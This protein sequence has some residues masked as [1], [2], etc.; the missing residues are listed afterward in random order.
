M[1]SHLKL[2]WNYFFGAQVWICFWFSLTPQKSLSNPHKVLTREWLVA[3]MCKT[4]NYEEVFKRVSA[5]HT[6]I[7]KILASPLGQVINRPGDGFPDS[8]IT[9]ECLKQ[10]ENAGTLNWT[11]VRFDLFFCFIPDQCSAIC[12]TL[13]SREDF[14]ISNFGLDEVWRKSWFEETQTCLYFVNLFCRAS[15]P[16]KQMFFIRGACSV[17]TKVD[18]WTNLN[19]CGFKCTV[20]LFCFVF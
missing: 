13:W 8:W 19:K 6:G 12:P 11:L 7:L 10:P 2:F 18:L 17:V 5:G 20:L 3:C 1:F 4:L 15:S 16:W 9:S 14:N